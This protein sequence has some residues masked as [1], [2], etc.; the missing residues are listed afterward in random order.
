M[1]KKKGPIRLDVGFLRLDLCLALF[2]LAD[3]VDDL[4]SGW[5]KISAFWSTGV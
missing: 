1:W 4:V 5:K 2:L 3:W